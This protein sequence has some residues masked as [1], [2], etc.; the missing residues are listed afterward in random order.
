M[1]VSMG[2]SLWAGVSGATVGVC[3]WATEGGCQWAGVIGC[4]WTSVGISGFEWAY[5]GDSGFQWAFLGRQWA[6][7]F[8]ITR[9]AK[10]ASGHLS[11]EQD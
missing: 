2:G 10:A 3:Q 5:V 8:R 6:S 7:I 4:Q 1:L 11:F 9:K